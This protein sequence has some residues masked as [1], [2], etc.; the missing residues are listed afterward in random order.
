MT[1]RAW[2]RWLT[3]LLLCWSLLAGH[4]ASAQD[5]PKL[6]GRV[7][8]AANILPPETETQLTA[9]LAQLEAE[10]TRQFV[11]ATVPDLQGY[12]IAEYGYRLGDAWGIGQKG[13]NNGIMLIVAPNE[14]RARIEVGPGL[15]AIVPDVL[16]SRI[17]RNDMIPRFKADDYPGGIVAGANSVMTLIRLPPGEAAAQARTLAAQQPE[18]NVR[19]GDVIFWLFIFFFF[20]LPVVRSM[21]G[22]RGRR[23][24]GGPVIIW[25]PGDWG[26]GGSSWGG[27]G[28]FSGGGGSFGG[29]GASGGW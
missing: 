20:I 23:F 18:K 3:G 24:G 12:D 22:K 8:D 16:A 10:T 19:I 9:Q 28:G 5:F 13:E 25:G 4:A 6:T 26:G 11:V 2:R 27:G 7:V 17:I 29:G 15:E 21:F 14:R 1:H